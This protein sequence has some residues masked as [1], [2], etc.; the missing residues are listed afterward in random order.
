MV[1]DSPEVGENLQD[2]YQARMIVK[3]KKK[4]SI[5]DQVRNPFELAKM[6]LQWLF[7]KSGPLTVGAAQVGGLARTKHARDNR[8]D[9]QMFVMPLSLEKSGEPLHDYSGFSAAVCQCRPDSRGRVSIRSTDPYDQPKIEPR[10]FSAEHDRKVIVAGLEMLR[11]IYAQPAFKDLW[12]VET[13]PGDTDLWTFAQTRGGT[14]YHPSGTCRMSDDGRSPVDSQ[15]RVRG[16]ERLRV[17]DA[18][19]MPT[20]VST[21]TNAATYM[22]AERGVEMMLNRS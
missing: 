10:Y 5:N 14:V 18:S 3:L 22:I 6:G 17:M 8:A 19:V 4:M 7:N 21:N 9:V 15:L 1:A 11:D 13:M 2:H 16:V 20:V 12:D